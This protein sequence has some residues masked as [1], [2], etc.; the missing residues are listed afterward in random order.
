VQERDRGDGRTTTIVEERELVPTQRSRQL[1][2][3]RRSSVAMMLAGMICAWI[4]LAAAAVTTLLGFRLAFLLAD[5]NRSTAFV[6]FIY[7]ISAPLVEPFENI[8]ANRSID[9]GGIFEPATLVAGVTYLIAATLLMAFIYGL[10]TTTPR[11]EHRDR[12]DLVRGH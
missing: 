6:D 3:P 8:F 10:A 9:G 11:V 2:T 4:G 7:D 12:R 1:E 5:A